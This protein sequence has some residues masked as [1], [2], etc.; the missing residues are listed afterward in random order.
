MTERLALLRDGGYQR[1]LVSSATIETRTHS[2]SPEHEP[3]HETVRIAANAAARETGRLAGDGYFRLEEVVEAGRI[4]RMRRTV[5]AV[6]AAERPPVFA[7]L[8]DDFWS[9][10]QSEAPLGFVEAH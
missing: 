5:E 9:I 7:F 8:F 10:A 2:N 4:G 1:Q 3:A 6:R